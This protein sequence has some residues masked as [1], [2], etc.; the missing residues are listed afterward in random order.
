MRA[1]KWLLVCRCGVD[2]SDYLHNHVQSRA[3]SGRVSGIRGILGFPGPIACPLM[4][5]V[6]AV[7]ADD[8]EGALDLDP[9]GGA[10]AAQQ[11]PEHLDLDADGTNARGVGWPQH[12]TANRPGVEFLALTGELLNASEGAVLRIPARLVTQRALDNDC[13]ERREFRFTGCCSHAVSSTL[14][15]ESARSCWETACARRHPG[16]SS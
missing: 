8:V 16:H 15:R 11:L 5:V 14:W 12:G 6:V 9:P 13:F 10:L 1:S 2:A 3:R 7:F 4:F